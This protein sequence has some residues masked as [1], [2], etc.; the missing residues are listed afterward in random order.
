[1]EHLRTKSR[2]LLNKIFRH[3]RWRRFWALTQGWTSNILYIVAL[4]LTSGQFVFIFGDIPG[5]TYWQGSITSLQL[6]VA[7][8]LWLFQPRERSLSN[9]MGLISLKRLSRRVDDFYHRAAFL[10]EPTPELK[11]ELEALHQELDS[12]QLMDQVEGLLRHARFN[13]PRMPMENP[14]NP[15]P[16]LPVRAPAYAP[17]LP[18][19]ST[20]MPPPPPPVC[21]AP[22]TPSPP[23]PTPPTTV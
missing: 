22:T 23:A 9:Y 5:R 12:L 21:I 10:E 11:A 8:F 17:D 13:E 4:A 1:M 6:L 20:Y 14:L 3:Q 15:L 19:Y 2:Y 18:P 16:M 7:A